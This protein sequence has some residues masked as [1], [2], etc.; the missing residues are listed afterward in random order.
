MVTLVFAASMPPECVYFLDEAFP[1]KTAYDVNWRPCASFSRGGLLRAKCGPGTG[2]FSHYK[3]PTVRTLTVLS[4]RNIPQSATPSNGSTHP[5]SSAPPSRP[6]LEVVLIKCCVKLR[7]YFETTKHFA[8]RHGI[9]IAFR[10]DIAI[11]VAIRSSAPEQAQFAIQ[12][13]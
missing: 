2:F 5:C 13:D 8:W 11:G 4:V 12:A 7:Y 6:L 10:S 3:S 9:A 1:S